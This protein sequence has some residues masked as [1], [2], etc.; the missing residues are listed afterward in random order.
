[1]TSGSQP[2]FQLTAP[3]AAVPQT[4][5][6]FTV[7]AENPAGGS[8]DTSFAGTVH[9]TSSDSLAVLPADFTFTP[10]DQGT[11]G[12]GATLKRS[13]GQTITATDTVNSAIIGTA[14]VTVSGTTLT[15]APT[16]LAFG[17]QAIGT[18]NIARKV[19]LTNQT[20]AEINIVSIAIT[21][22]NASDFAETATTCGSTLAVSK[23]CTLSFT[24][25][26][27]ALGATS[28]TLSL[29][30]AAGNSPQQIALSGTGIVQVSVVPATVSFAATNVGKTSA[31]RVITVRNSLKATLTFSGTPFTFTGADPGDFNQSATT[32]GSTLA[33]YGHCTVSITF[34]PTAQGIHT[35]VLNIADNANPGSQTV[36]LSGKGR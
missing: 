25:T 13:G 20:G 1:M 31:T 4:S 16:L 6:N 28:A 32:C 11:Q 23:S 22:T 29:T 27:V 17:N 21:G 5:F 9:F 7:T 36:S 12:F 19:T 15:F 3:A 33:A 18:T 35:A 26:P 24:F 34:T 30:D 8:T 2:S 10:N 14:T